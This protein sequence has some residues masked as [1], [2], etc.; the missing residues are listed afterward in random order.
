[1]YLF[2]TLKENIL[3]RSWKFLPNSQ[4]EDRHMIA[5]G[6]I[7]FL[8]NSRSWNR[9]LGNYLTGP[10]TAWQALNPEFDSR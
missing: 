10:L 9:K 6:L 5:F 8:E 2:R 1:M 4:S 7:A 3:S